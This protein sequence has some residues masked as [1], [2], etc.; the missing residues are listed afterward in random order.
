LLY[1]ALGIAT[2]GGAYLYFSKN[3]SDEEKLKKKAHANEEAR[4]R[5]VYESAAAVKSRAD[6]TVEEGKKKYE[7]AKVS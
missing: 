2:I 7:D 3:F 1:T 5:K 6:N 4:Q